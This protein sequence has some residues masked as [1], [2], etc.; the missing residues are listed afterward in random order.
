M[1]RVETGPVQF[2]DDWPGVFIR[3]DNAFFYALTVG[4]AIRQAEMGEK[5]HALFVMQLK[6]LAAL[7]ASAQ[8][9]D[10]GKMPEGTQHIQRAGVSPEPTKEKEPL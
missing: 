5:M 3:G 6:G 1:S 9:R 4:Q 7:L 2:E 8:V 10:G